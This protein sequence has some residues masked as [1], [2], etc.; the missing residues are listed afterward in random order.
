MFA[1]F[2]LNGNGQTPI[3]D[4]HAE[5]SVVDSRLGRVVRRN[6]MSPSWQFNTE[7]RAWVTC[8]AE[9]IDRFI[10][11]IGWQKSNTPLLSGGCIKYKSVISVL[12]LKA[13]TI[14]L[15]HPT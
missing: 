15:N 9:P 7:M 1:T 6:A 10:G 12:L 14:M 11:Y 2:F 4:V 13:G 5:F 8:Q 3:A